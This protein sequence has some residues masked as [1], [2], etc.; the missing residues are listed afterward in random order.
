MCGD[1]E[2]NKHIV[3]NLGVR[4]LHFKKTVNYALD[5]CS[6]NDKFKS[7]SYFGAASYNMLKYKVQPFER[8]LCKICKEELKEMK[9]INPTDRPPPYIIG[10]KNKNMF[11][12]NKKDWKMVSVNYGY[13]Q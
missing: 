13:S 7:Y 8:L 1:E 10:D 6:V 11:S 2:K 3:K 4:L 5:H 12:Y 9:F